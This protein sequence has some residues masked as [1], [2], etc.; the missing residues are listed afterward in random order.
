MHG[1]GITD[2]TDRYLLPAACDVQD[3]R[4]SC[5]HYSC[6]IP[7]SDE[8]SDAS[9]SSTDMASFPGK[10]TAPMQRCQGNSKCV[11]RSTESCHVHK[12][13]NSWTPYCQHPRQRCS[14]TFTAAMASIKASNARIDILEKEIVSLRDQGQEQ[15]RMMIELARKVA[16]NF[17]KF[18]TRLDAMQTRFGDCLKQ[19]WDSVN[20]AAGNAAEESP[21]LPGWE[22]HWSAYYSCYYYWDPVSNQS[23]WER[24][25][26]SL[27]AG[28]NDSCT[29][30][31]DPRRKIATQD[32]FEGPF[33]PEDVYIHD[34]VEEEVEILDATV[35]APPIAWPASQSGSVLEVLMIIEAFLDPKY[36]LRVLLALQNMFVTVA[37]V[38]IHCDFRRVLHSNALPVHQAAG[39]QSPNC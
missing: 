30:P 15:N 14:P 17:N 29:R 38:G 9:S 3:T 5:S 11:F 2:A 19:I 22:Q 18:E 33:Y 20:P 12:F 39:A 27:T 13:G 37:N 21:M 32:C 7:F 16:G 35:A 6:G 10:T 36:R 25:T 31:Q 26:A 34:G 8:H 28:L 24:P 4:A 1:N 23:V